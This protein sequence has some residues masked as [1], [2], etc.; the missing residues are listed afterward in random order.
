MAEAP[1]EEVAG[2]FFCHKC[3]VEIPRVLPVS[4]LFLLNS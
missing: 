2:R 3:A 4:K 1:Q